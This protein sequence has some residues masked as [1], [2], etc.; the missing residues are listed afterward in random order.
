M[1]HTCAGTNLQELQGT[2]VVAQHYLKHR[3]INEQPSLTEY[4]VE[5]YLSAS[6]KSTSSTSFTY[7]RSRARHAPRLLLRQ[8]NLLMGKV[9][10]NSAP[11]YNVAYLVITALFWHPVN[12]DYRATYIQKLYVSVP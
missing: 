1:V 10:L 9:R 7:H 3:A 2:S 12:T 8:L 4:I 6:E 5:Q 11:S